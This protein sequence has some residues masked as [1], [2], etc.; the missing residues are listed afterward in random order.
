MHHHFFGPGHDNFHA[1]C[2]DMQDDNLH[3]GPELVANSNAV[4]DDEV[5]DIDKVITMELTWR[6]KICGF[7]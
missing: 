5:D 1:F 6:R 3:D 7:Q 2:A 4:K